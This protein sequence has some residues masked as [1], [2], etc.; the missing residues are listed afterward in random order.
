MDS[1]TRFSTLFYPK[2]PPGPHTNRQKRFREI[3]RFRE[4][5]PGRIF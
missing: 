2:T 1:V 5:F 3:F 4:T